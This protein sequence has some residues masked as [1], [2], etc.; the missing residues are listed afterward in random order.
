M[1]SDDGD[2]AQESDFGVVFY[3][4][5]V[6]NGLLEL[7][8]GVFALIPAHVDVSRNGPTKKKNH[9]HIEYD[10]IFKYTAKIPYD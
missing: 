1:R 2:C 4:G 6:I 5:R 9:G 7:E 8:T 10:D 3:D